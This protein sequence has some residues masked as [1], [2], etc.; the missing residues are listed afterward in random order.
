[1]TRE[2]AVAHITAI[3]RTCRGSAWVPAQHV[4]DRAL[5]GDLADTD[6]LCL[7]VGIDPGVNADQAIARWYDDHF[8]GRPR[9]DLPEAAGREAAESI[10]KLLEVKPGLALTR[11][12]RWFIV[13]CGY[14]FNQTILANPLDGEV[15]QYECPQCGT[16]GTYRAPLLDVG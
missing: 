14:D 15:Y 6:V 4:K 5:R 10:A 8:R 16:T 12:E 7:A 2:E 9:P 1:M 11:F 3:S 13:G